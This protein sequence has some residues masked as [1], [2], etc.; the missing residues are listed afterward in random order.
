MKR[1]CTSGRR[2]ETAGVTAPPSV[3]GK[4]LSGDRLAVIGPSTF[5]EVG[6]RK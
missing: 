3:R 6:Q 2:T 4:N 5:Y 1:L